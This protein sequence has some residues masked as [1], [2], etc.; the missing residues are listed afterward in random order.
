MMVFFLSARKSRRRSSMNASKTIKHCI[1]EK[2]SIKTLGRQGH[3]KS[4]EMLVFFS[5]SI[6]LKNVFL[7]IFN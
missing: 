2:S 6:E 4:G 5:K 1:G 7:S 3:A